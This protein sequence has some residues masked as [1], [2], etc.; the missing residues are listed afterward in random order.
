[1]TMIALAA[2]RFGRGLPVDP[3][4]TRQANRDA[5]KQGYITTVVSLPP[6]P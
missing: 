4:Q 6:T 2:V 1:M 3:V 5:G